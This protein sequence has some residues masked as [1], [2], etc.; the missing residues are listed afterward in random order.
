M[1]VGCGRGRPNV[2]VGEA[3]GDGRTDDGVGV[4]AGVSSIA[5]IVGVAICAPGEVSGCGAIP[6]KRTASQPASIGS[7][8]TPMASIRRGNPGARLWVLDST[9]SPGNPRVKSL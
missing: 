3:A 2:G 5:A 4:G 7:S 6:R 1:H 8:I 9:T